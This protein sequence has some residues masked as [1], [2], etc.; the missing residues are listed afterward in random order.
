MDMDGLESMDWTKGQ[1]DWRAGNVEKSKSGAREGLKGW[2]RASVM[3]FSSPG[4][5]TMSLVNSEM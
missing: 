2:E 5:W 1:G 3:A 4:T